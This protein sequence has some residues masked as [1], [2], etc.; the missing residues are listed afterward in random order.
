MSSERSDWNTP[1]NLLEVVRQFDE[2]GLDPCSNANSIVGAKSSLTIEDNGLQ[3]IWSGHGLVYVNPPYGREIE[4]WAMMCS[5]KASFGVEVIA[6]LP[7]RTDAMWW[8]KWIKKA[9]TVCF[10]RGRLKFLGA[11]FSAPFPS[12]IAYWG[13]RRSRFKKVFKPHGWVVP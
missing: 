6:L 11:R 3:A 2:I 9:N 1:A 12:A 8:Q 10:W 5:L 13:D 7:A 4:P